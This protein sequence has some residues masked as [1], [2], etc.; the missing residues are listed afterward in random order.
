MDPITI[1]IADDIVNTREDIK[2]LL[3]FEEDIKVVGEAGDGEE[4]VRV[5]EELQPD[6]VLMDINMPGLDGISATEIITERVPQTAVVI[7]SIQGEQEYLRKAMAAGASD[8]LLKPFTSQELADTIRRVNEK[9]KRR[10][11]TL[12]RLQEKP[13]AAPPGKVVVVFGTK[14]GVGRTTLT[15]NLAVALAQEF[16]KRVTVVDLDLA[17]GDV[18]LLFN[19]NLPGS[20][21]E[22]AREPELNEEIV[23]AYTATHLTG[24]KVLGAISSREEDYT[25]LAAR[26]PEIFEIL[27]EGCD[28]LLVDTPPVL[29]AAVA[30]ALDM[31]DEILVVGGQD[32][33]ALKR[34]K[35]D[36][37]F[38]AA[39]QLG[40]KI[41]VVL[42]AFAEGG[43]KPADM[44]RT[45]GL[46]FTGIIAADGRT[47]QMAANKGTPFVLL[48]KGSRITQDVYRLA[49]KLFRKEAVK[50]AK[51]SLLGKILSF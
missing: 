31:A 12:L 37:E 33:P 45:L 13:E 16:H 25:D 28:F 46:S 6:I 2:R 34:L 44:E 40:E 39:H 7:I 47:V 1:V 3:F 21:A 24:V 51:R 36:V 30:Q 5:A 4:A 22:L 35:A 27:K 32:L 15:C 19:L 49:E 20:I 42:N 50:E 8:Y 43:L 17:G 23:E 29:S 38:L 11:G 14:G 41:R 18:A 9:V 10:Q 48:Q 26:L